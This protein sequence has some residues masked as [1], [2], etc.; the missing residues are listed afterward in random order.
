MG[1]TAPR[2]GRTDGYH[3]SVHLFVEAFKLSP[4]PTCCAAALYVL[5]VHNNACVSPFID[6]SSIFTTSIKRV[7]AGRWNYEIDLCMHAIVYMHIYVSNYAY[8]IV[9]V[10]VCWRNYSR[11]FSSDRLCMSIR[12]L[13]GLSLENACKI[14]PPLHVSREQLTVF[15]DRSCRAGHQQQQ[16]FADSPPT[17]NHHRDM[18]MA[19]AL[20]FSL[21][22]TG[23]LFL[24][25]GWCHDA[26]HNA[27]MI[28]TRRD[29][30]A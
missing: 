11:V 26:R 8:I 29:N 17:Q 25:H 14:N 7:Q 4:L 6:R 19:S 30:G 9:C 23:V 12:M 18:D 1:S 24:I 5:V 27:K 15:S 22:G 28:C 20:N 2:A 16:Q 3:R 10:C 21:Q 13:P